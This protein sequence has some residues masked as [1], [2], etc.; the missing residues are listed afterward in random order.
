MSK[1]CP[2]CRIRPA[3][4]LKVIALACDRCAVDERPTEWP[5]MSH[6]DSARLWLACGGWRGARAPGTLPLISAH[7]HFKPVGG[8]D[9]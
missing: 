9:G 1:L 8:S 3:S 5:T 7:W 6:R 4:M 2:T